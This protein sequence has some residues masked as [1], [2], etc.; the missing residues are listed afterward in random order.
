M[1]NEIQLILV[2]AGAEYRA[3]KRGLGQCRNVPPVV[4]IPAGPQPVRQF[5]AAFLS[6]W[7][8]RSRL[9]TGVLLVGLGGSLA[10]EYEVGDGVL[11][12]Q[13]WN[14]FEPGSEMYQCDRGL[15]AQL[16]EQLEVS[17]GV[18]VTCDRVITSA[19]EKR[20]LRDRYGAD[21]VDMEA[22]ALLKAMPDS[23]IAILRIISDDCYHDLPDFSNV[24]DAQGAIAPVPLALSFLS[25]PI[26]ALRLIR[27]ALKGLRSLENM[28]SV[29]GSKPM[30]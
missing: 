4:A 9:Q 13:V 3:V 15:T 24:I 26:A 14:G 2:P 27:G 1:D 16:V 22:A 17:T 7:Q 6:Q 23:K 20:Q 19:A 18:G 25:R 21:V 8:D 30:G 12:E 10:P 29:L 28:A 11:I 5:L